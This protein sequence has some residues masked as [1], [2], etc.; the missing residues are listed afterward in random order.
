MP[1]NHS[2]EQTISKIA[3]DVKSN[4]RVNSGLSRRWLQDFCYSKS[5]EKEPQIRAVEQTVTKN[6]IVTENNR[7]RIN[8]HTHT[9]THTHTQHMTQCVQC[10]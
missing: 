6:N 3:N 2:S 9:H 4:R 1:A 5:G 10:H 7:L 8:T